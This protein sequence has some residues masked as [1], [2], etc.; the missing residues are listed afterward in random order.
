MKPFRF[1]DWNRRTFWFL[2]LF[3]H[4]FI[5]TLCFIS[6]F[7]SP[8]NR[9]SFFRLNDKFCNIHPEKWRRKWV[10]GNLSFRICIP[11]FSFSPS[12]T[13]EM[14]KDR[15]KWR[16]CSSPGCVYVWGTAASSWWSSWCSFERRTSERKWKEERKKEKICLQKDQCIDIPPV[17]VSI[18]A[19]SL[20]C[21]ILTLLPTH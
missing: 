15:A 13:L 1:D 14:R 8:K 4:I 5:L 18:S 3:F 9:W 6:G 12:L 20:P 7:L 17:P 21:L 11:I 16:T 19:K 10:A 2:S